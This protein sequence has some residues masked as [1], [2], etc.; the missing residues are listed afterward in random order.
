[1]VMTREEKTQL[2]DELSERFK[3]TRGVVF[4]DYRGIT[5]KDSQDL[6]SKL[7]EA[8]I[9][10]KVIK[11]SLLRIVLE[12]AK[13]SVPDEVLAKPLAIAMSDEDE[14]TPAKL[15]V[16]AAKELEPLQILGGMVNN[17]FV[18]ELT[19]KRLA[20]LP[21]REELYA[22]VVGSMASPLTSMV[23]VLQGN[24]RGLVSVL[25]QRQAK[26]S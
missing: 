14:V 1:M 5:M 18:D 12:R 24:I 17:Q 3:H 10:Y 11:T 22:K 23:G 4:T 7:R 6:R 15:T 26:L 21:G 8:G 16:S 9:D 2:I 19:I 20:A 25:S 13:L